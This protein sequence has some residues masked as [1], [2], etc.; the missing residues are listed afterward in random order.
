MEKLRKAISFA[1]R[2]HDG[3]KRKYT[4]EPYVLHPIMV[5]KLMQALDYDEDTLCAAL[6]HDVVEDTGFTLHAIERGFGPKVAELVHFCTE[7]SKPEDGN[8]AVRKAMDADHYAKGPK[9]AQT[10]KVA[11]LVDN[12]ASIKKHDPNFWKVFKKEKEHLLSVLTKADARLVEVAYV[13]L[14]E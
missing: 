9:E 6:L 11:D 4:H 2:A 13:L 1:H 5:M 10:I 14:D 3:Q 8:R 7:V 12:A